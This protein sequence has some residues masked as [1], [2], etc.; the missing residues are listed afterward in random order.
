MKI[1]KEIKNQERVKGLKNTKKIKLDKIFLII[2]K[3]I[4]NLLYIGNLLSRMLYFKF[5]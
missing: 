4:Y 5:K 2:F 1:I 3:K